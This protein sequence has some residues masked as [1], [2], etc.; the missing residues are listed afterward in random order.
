MKTFKLTRDQKQTI[1]MR[2]I[3]EIQAETEEEAAKLALKDHGEIIDSETLYDTAENMCVAENDG[4]ATIE[5]LNNK[6]ELI[7]AN[8]LH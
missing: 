2:E 3:I 4:F 1:W 8:G 7:V 6:N 5:I